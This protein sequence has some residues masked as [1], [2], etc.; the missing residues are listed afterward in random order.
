M[1]Y[2]CRIDR[3]NITVEEIITAHQKY[4]MD[5]SFILLISEEG[6]DTKNPHYHSL[7]YSNSIEAFR[8]YL[9]RKFQLAGN[10]D[11]SISRTEDLDKYIAYIL[12][13][14]N[15]IYKN[16]ITDEQFKLASDRVLK[17]EAEKHL[18]LSDKVF[19]HLENLDIEYKDEIEFM[20]AVMN[21]FKLNKLAYPNRN[22]MT[23]FRIKFLMDSKSRQGLTVDIYDM[24]LAKIYGF[25]DFYHKD[26]I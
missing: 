20:S 1:Y 15:I 21:Y 5:S 12:K 26:H 23:Q 6:K 7:I 16:G 25:S 2:S 18:S 13:E 17:I 10:K 8:K 11:F 22:W 4:H 24:K 14:G 3:H 19:N 9:K